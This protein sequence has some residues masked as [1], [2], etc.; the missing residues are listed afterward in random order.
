MVTEGKPRREQ[1]AFMRVLTA[2]IP[3][4]NAMMAAKTA[5]YSPVALVAHVKPASSSPLYFLCESARDRLRRG[6][7]HGSIGARRACATPERSWTLLRHAGVE[8]SERILFEADEAEVPFFPMVDATRGEGSER[9]RI[10]FH[11]LVMLAVSTFVVVDGWDEPSRLVS[12]AGIF[13]FLL[14]GWLLSKHPRKVNWRGVF[15]GLMAQFLLGLAILRWSVGRRLLQC[16]GDKFTQFVRFTDHGSFFA[17][18]YLATGEPGGSLHLPPL[19]AFKVEAK[20]PSTVVTIFYFN[21]ILEVLYHIGVMQW[22]IVELGELLQSFVSTTA[23]E[24]MN[25]AA[26]I[27]VGHIVAAAVI[28][29]YLPLMTASELN[30]VVVSGLAS[31]AGQRVSC[32][33]PDLTSKRLSKEQDFSVFQA[34]PDDEVLGERPMLAAFVELGI[35]AAHLVSASFMSAPAALACAK[36]LHPET[37]ESKTRAEHIDR[38]TGKYTTL[39]EA[40]LSGAIRATALY[41]SWLVSMIVFTAA[42]HQGNAIVTWITGLLGTSEFTLEYMLS[43][44]FMPVALAMGVPWEESRIVGE[45]VAVKTVVNE[46]IAYHRLGQLKKNRLLSGRSATIAT[47]ALCG[48]SNFGALGTELATIAT[49][50]PEKREVVARMAWRSF[51]A[52]SM[53]CFLTA[54]IAEEKVFYLD[55]DRREAEE[56]AEGIHEG[57]DGLHSGSECDDGRQD[58]RV[59]SRRPRRSRQARIQQSFVLPVRYTSN[60]R[61]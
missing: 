35:S 23:A 30:V 43:Y 18:E 32:P 34:F 60:T 28:Q 3:D 19:F 33:I 59:Q 42:V 61:P 22:A 31:V 6:G 58:G 38:D 14:V 8:V 49:L 53:A 11:C 17:F 29:P 20:S 40:G 36:L 15:W 56:R 25:A 4:L 12:G 27:F 39:L 1:R 5:A 52:G 21:W 54:S 37:E 41:A 13:F 24:S 55:G 51:V 9:A 57:V 45:L 47:Y 7:T 48:F 50:V 2:S 16:V 26:N 44:L 46:F 10:G